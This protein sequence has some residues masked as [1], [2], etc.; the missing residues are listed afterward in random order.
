VRVRFRVIGRDGA[1][2]VQQRR[3]WRWRKLSFAQFGPDG[4]LRYVSLARYDDAVYFSRVLSE[5]RK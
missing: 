3:W 1:Y 5:A 2:C 4:I